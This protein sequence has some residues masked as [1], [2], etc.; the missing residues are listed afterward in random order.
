MQESVAVV[1]VPRYDCFS[2][3]CQKLEDIAYRVRTGCF[4][5]IDQIKAVIA[6]VLKNQLHRLASLRDYVDFVAVDSLEAAIG[7]FQSLT[8]LDIEERAGIKNGLALSVYSPSAEAHPGKMSN[9]GRSDATYHWL[10]QRDEPAEGAALLLQFIK[11]G[12]KTSTHFH[13]RTVESFLSLAGSAGIR[14]N[15]KEYALGREFFRVLPG[16]AH[17]LV[18]NNGPAINL[19]YMNAYDP[20]LED[21]HYCE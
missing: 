4:A 7:D 17:Q 18:S 6:D 16:T 8:S 2:A 19:L 1:V 21:H 9:S 11:S 5:K 12:G 10:I 15:G 14:I 3:T 20:K 13:S